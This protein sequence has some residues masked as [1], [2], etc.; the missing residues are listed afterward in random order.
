MINILIK[1]GFLC[2]LLTYSFVVSAQTDEKSTL[3]TIETLERGHNESK[4]PAKKTT[5]STNNTKDF[6]RHH[7]RLPVTFEG[8]AIEL[9]TSDFPLS[10]D[11]HLFEQF[12]K[13]YYDQVKGQGYSYLILV[14]FSSK[15][16]IEQYIGKVLVYRAPEA[17][18][19]AYKKGK[20][21]FK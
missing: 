1:L 21:S 12:G 20:R 19:V 4:E 11:Y 16:A 14:D 15:K 17:R 6:Y 9:T 2:L 13:V 8:Y 5:V 7:K 3:V 10:R 18:I